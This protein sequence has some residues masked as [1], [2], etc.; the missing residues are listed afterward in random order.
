[1]SNDNV[2]ACGKKRGRE[3]IRKDLIFP[4][5]SQLLNTPSSKSSPPPPPNPPLVLFLPPLSI[6]LLL[7]LKSITV[8]NDIDDALIGGNAATEPGEED[9]AVDASSTSGAAL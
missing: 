8:S 7:P 2:D 9:T 5:F 1:M 3:I 6:S 4:I